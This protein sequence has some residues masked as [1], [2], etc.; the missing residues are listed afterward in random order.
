[1]ED[2]DSI[3]ATFN[4]TSAQFGS[5]GKTEEKVVAQ[6]HNTLDP[7]YA[8]IRALMVANGQTSNV[9]VNVQGNAY[10]GIEDVIVQAVLNA[11]QTNRGGLATAI[12]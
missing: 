4:K 3:W 6:A 7:E 1:M 9:T 5:K 10:A 2:L 11:L 12:G 8:R